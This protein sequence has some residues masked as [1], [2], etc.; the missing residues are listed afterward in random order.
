MASEHIASK[1]SPFVSH[2]CFEKLHENALFSLF[3]VYIFHRLAGDFR[4]SILTMPHSVRI[5]SILKR[6]IVVAL[7]I[8]EFHMNL[9]RRQSA[10]ITIHLRDA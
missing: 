6:V 9:H 3:L 10:R 8:E 4:N 7:Y 5:D 1:E 2:T